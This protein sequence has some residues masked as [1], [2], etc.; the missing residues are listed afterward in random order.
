[1]VIVH[2]PKPLS[3][4][5]PLC[6]ANTMVVARLPDSSMVVACTSCGVC[7]EPFP[8]LPH[9]KESWRHTRTYLRKKPTPDPELD[10]YTLCYGAF[11]TCG[12][13]F[14]RYDRPMTC[15]LE[16]LDYARDYMRANGLAVVGVEKHLHPWGDLR[17]VAFVCDLDKIEV[18][19]RAS[20]DPT[21]TGYHRPAWAGPS[22]NRKAKHPERDVVLQKLAADLHYAA[23]DLDTYEYKDQYG[24][25]PSEQGYRDSFDLLMSVEGLDT[26][27][28]MIEDADTNA[29]DDLLSRLKARRDELAAVGSMSRKSRRSFGTTRKG[30]SGRW[31]R[32]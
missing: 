19:H 22:P 11:R 2:T 3:D 20:V 25:Y 24:E 26:A 21:D 1:M 12:E 10:R 8:C 5:C 15:D 27:I 17:H 16:A 9:A 31:R 7:S 29:Y 32:A 30:V 13:R 6:K 28:E 14:V 18:L 4:E 23:Y